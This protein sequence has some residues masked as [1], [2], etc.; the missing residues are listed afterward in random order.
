MTRRVACLAASFVAVAGGQ[1]LKFSKRKIKQRF[2]GAWVLVSF[3]RKITDGTITYP[4]GTDPIG[5]LTYDGL[6]RMSVQ[7]MRRDRP[8]FTSGTRQ[9]TPEEIQAA[10]AGYTAYYGPYEVYE[11]DGFVIHRLEACSFP[12]WVGTEQKRFFEFVDE[13]LVLRAKTAEGDSK[14]VWRRAV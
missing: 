10:F 13:H 6:G 3:E 12:N 1:Q 5:R 2:E 4:L 11:K 9:G 8:R 7:I 14:L